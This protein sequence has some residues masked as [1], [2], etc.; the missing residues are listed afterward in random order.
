M[1]TVC[2]GITI[3]PVNAARRK[4]S[5]A[6]SLLRFTRAVKAR[7]SLSDKRVLIKF[8]RAREL[9]GGFAGEVICSAIVSGADT[10]SSN[11]R[12]GCSLRWAALDTSASR[13]G[14]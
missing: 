3:R 11:V 7:Y 8:F 6:D 5:L 12:D 1:A 13:F 14:L 10:I 9:C 2:S 4:N